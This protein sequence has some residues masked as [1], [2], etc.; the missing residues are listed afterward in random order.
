MLDV[1]IIDNA[2]ADPSALAAALRPMLTPHPVPQSDSRTRGLILET[3]A[4]TADQANVRAT[5]PA[6]RP[7]LARFVTAEDATFMLAVNETPPT[8]PDRFMMRPHIDRLWRSDGFS[9]DPPRRTTVVFLHFPPAAIGGELA[10]FAP[11]AFAAAPAIP[12]EH[13]R[14]TIATHSGM[15]VDPRPGRACIMAG[16]L[17][18]A[19]LGYSAQAHETWRL[20]IVVAEFVAV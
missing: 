19:V 20:A 16:H 14:N 6:L 15:L 10:I 7:I 13:A 3:S 8:S 5:I 9:G 1:T 12:R 4:R 2:I 18:H 11:D 17:P